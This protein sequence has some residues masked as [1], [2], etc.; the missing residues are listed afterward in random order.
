MRRL[1]AF[2]ARVIGFLLLLAAFAVLG[3]DLLA[4]RENGVFVPTASGQLWHY[5]HRASLGALQEGVQRYISPQLWDP[6]IVTA[7]QFWVVPVLAVP[8]IFLAWVFR[9]RRR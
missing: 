5:V 3:H 4:W 6:F 7:L 2:L 9:K 8:G 1:F